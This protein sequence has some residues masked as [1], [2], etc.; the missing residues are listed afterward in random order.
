MPAALVFVFAAGVKL[1]RVDAAESGA[2]LT[3]AILSSSF[4]ES[5]RFWSEPRSFVP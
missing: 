3:A 2:A 4:R 5:G 1:R